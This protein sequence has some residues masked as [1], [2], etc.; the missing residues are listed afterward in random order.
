MFEWNPSYS[1]NVRELDA[2]HQNLFKLAAEFHTALVQGKGKLVVERTLDRMVQYSRVH[3][4][5]EERLM[6][7]AGYPGIETH[8]AEHAALSVRV[9]QLQRDVSE[10]RV[11]LPMEVLQF[12]KEWLLMHTAGSDAKYGACLSDFANKDKPVAAQ[13]AAQETAAPAAQ[14]TASEAAQGAVAQAAQGAAA[15]TAQADNC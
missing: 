15:Q 5:H 4:V 9:L 7:A 1:V 2:Q 10:G 14:E 12:L 6:Q 8:R 11:T 13:E 3:F